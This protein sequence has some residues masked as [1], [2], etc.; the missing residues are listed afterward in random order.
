MKISRF[1]KHSDKRCPDCEVS[2]I[3]M[4]DGKYYCIICD[5]YKGKT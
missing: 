2:L 1:G 3:E 4:D 5:E